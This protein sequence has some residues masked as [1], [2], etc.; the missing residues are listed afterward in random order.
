MTTIHLVTHTHWDRE[1]Y[2]TFQQFRLKLVHLVDGLLD[3]LDTDPQF[4]YFMLDGQTI[5][6]ED[7]LEIRP[8]READL[9]KYVQNGRLL[10]GPWYLMADVFLAGPE[11]LIRNLQEGTRIAARFGPT[12]PV[13][14]LPDPFGHIGQMPQIFQGF[15]LKYASLWRGLSD[16][17]NEFWWQAPDGSRVLLGYLRQSYSNAAGAFRK[18]PLDGA[19]DI[20]RQVE[21]LRQTTSGS[22]LLLM[23]GTDHQEPSPYT[24][25]GI[26]AM[27]QMLNGSGQILHSTLPQ[28][29]A[30]VEEQLDLEN[31]P[32]VTGELRSSRGTMLLPGV[33]STR[34]WIKQRNAAGETLLTK[35]AEPFSAWAQALAAAQF[36][37]AGLRRPQD[38]LRQAWRLLLQC[39]PHDSICGCSIDP[40]HE[41]MKA[42]FDQSEQMGEV[43][44]AQSL[45]GLTQCIDTR[46]PG[47]TDPAAPESTPIGAFVIFNAADQ[48]RGDAV[49]VT[50]DLPDETPFTVVD[51]NGADLPFQVL[52]TTPA[53]WATQSVLDGAAMQTLLNVAAPGM[54][55]GAG[56]LLGAALLPQTQPAE[57]TLALTIAP[58]GEPDRAA[59]ELARKQVEALIDVGTVKSFHLVT[60][61]N[62]TATLRIA[63]PSVPAMGYRTLWVRPTAAPAVTDTTG[64]EPAHESTGLQTIENAFFRVAVEADGCL[65]VQDLRTGQSYSGQNRFLDSGDRG[66]TY[67]I[68]EPADDHPRTA[69]L[70]GVETSRGAV[71]QQMT[72]HL[73]MDLPAGLTADRQRRAETTVALPITTRVTLTR[74]VPRVDIHTE[75]DNQAN[76]HRLRVQFSAPFPAN[77]AASGAAA[78][79]NGVTDAA[80]DVVRRP[81]N[82]PLESGPEFPEQPRPEVPQRA[83]SALSDGQRGLLVAN[84]G[85][86]EVELGAD[87]SGQ[88]AITVTLL[89]CVGWLSCGDLPNRPG[90]AGPG[91]PTPAA[92]MPG[93]WTFDYA[94]LPFDEAHRL[95]AYHQ[96]YAFQTQ[97]RAVSAGLHGGS[98]PAQASFFSVDAPGF[99]VSAVKIA[100]DGNG[101]I[102][103]GYNLTDQPITGSLTALHAHPAERVTLAEQTIA[104]LSGGDLTVRPHEIV[105]VRFIPE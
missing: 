1:W 11:A 27:N 83:F 53:S 94:I 20:Q 50:V 85:L 16:Q 36:P 33:L 51:E 89:R 62:P 97:L 10:I 34:M 6:L 99:A 101:W 12:L 67:T 22:D 61:I 37:A 84:H 69:R 39:Q 73:V 19:L 87:A 96:A 49:T 35:W 98:L 3:L 2:L 104:P 60:R 43:L 23:N 17:P 47:G 58:A 18:G 105:S 13:G 5:V 79:V 41:E 42:R 40:V 80:F 74:G 15:G 86:P 21:L 55:T 44:T 72:L 8:E 28:Y 91:F 68:S 82:A 30:S 71:Q 26:A 45:A 76:D 103:R 48:P 52:A 92:Q 14:Y 38:A 77:D 59:W 64:H 70:T 57:A 9:R 46:A 90:H 75:V 78:N 54:D 95:D 63:V 24:A 66:D 32:V 29:F 102:A 100:N 93:R 31:L 4:Q 25:A 7:Y 65:A 88:A 56:L 81:V